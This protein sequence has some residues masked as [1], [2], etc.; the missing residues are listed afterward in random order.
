MLLAIGVAGAYAADEPNPAKA[1]IDRAWAGARTDPDASSRDARA[2]LEILN[3]QPDVDLEIRARLLL[4]DHLS[5]R[6]QAAAEQQIAQARELLTK[7]TRPGLQAGVLTCEGT[8]R[9]TVG[10]FAKARDLYE[11]AVQVATE[12]TDKE[13]LAGALFSRGYLLGVQ[14]QY[15][16]GLTDLKR[17]QAVFEDIDLPDH[18]AARWP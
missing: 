8:I 13:M 12:T 18:G 11:R 16:A 10:D 17:A 7:A 3:R 15:A 2:A 14:G 4:C 5:E 6:D 9:E 1:L